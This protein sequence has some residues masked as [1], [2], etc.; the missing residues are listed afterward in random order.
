MEK[1]AGAL[2]SGV[3]RKIRKFVAQITLAE[4]TAG[5]SDHRSCS[6]TLE[7]YSSHTDHRARRPLKDSSKLEMSVAILASAPRP[8]ALGLGRG[9]QPYHPD[10]NSKAISF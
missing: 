5:K 10:S 9:Y 4:K 2:S 8:H 3:D 1:P 7:G 6:T